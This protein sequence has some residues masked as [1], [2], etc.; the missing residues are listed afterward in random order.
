M[1]NGLLWET[2]A[3]RSK[4]G[5]PLIFI[6]L[7]GEVGVG[8]GI[9]QDFGDKAWVV[10]KILVVARGAGN[11]YIGIAD[12]RFASLTDCADISKPLAFTR[13]SK[14]RISRRIR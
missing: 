13:S 4:V 8:C 2:S 9:R 3:Y 5:Q 1:T 6:E 11:H 10:Q 14:S 12:A 7:F